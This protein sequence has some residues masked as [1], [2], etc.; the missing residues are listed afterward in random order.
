VDDIYLLYDPVTMARALAATPT[1]FKKDG[2]RIGWGPAKPE[3]IVPVYCDPA[4]FLCHL[5]ASGGGLP[6]LVTGFISCL[7]APGRDTNNPP[8]I[9]FTL[10]CIDLR[11][12]RLHDLVED[13]SCG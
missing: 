11:H 7:G 13:V 5:D 9:S 10:V 8:F 12:D 2:L 4:T 3:L 6:H 1:I